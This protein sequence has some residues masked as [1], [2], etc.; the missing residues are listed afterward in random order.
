[1]SY[2]LNF[3][4]GRLQASFAVET[5][6]GSRGPLEAKQEGSLARTLVPNK[7]SGKSQGNIDLVK[8]YRWTLSNL[9]DEDL[10]EVPYIK[11]KEFRSTQA[12][13]T[14]QI[15]FY[16]SLFGDSTKSII[17][18]PQSTGNVLAPYEGIWPHENETGFTYKF[19]YFNKIGMELASEPWAGLDSIGEAINKGTDAV[20]SLFGAD[21]GKALKNFTAVVENGGKAAL[22]SQYPAVGVTDR[23]KIFMAHNDRNINISFVLYNTIS[24]QEW[25]DNSDFIRI[26]MSQNLFNKKDYITGVPPVFYS[27]YIPGQYFCWAA[28]VTNFKVE[29][30]GNQRLI[31][32]N[33]E[34]IVPDAYQ[35]DITLTELV[36]PSKNQ[37]E[38]LANGDAINHVTVTTIDSNIRLGT[39]NNFNNIA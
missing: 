38:A 6:T 36:K 5:V 39:Q 25:L 32:Y 4:R 31:D 29:H 2:P 9:P 30:L 20:G 10:K 24:T 7:L 12:S 23:P 8:D 33:G 28:S 22:M 35:V 3:L 21:M 16:S 34:I 27:V 18:A 13:I 37:F 1:M 26:F 15:K 14:K 11:L 17:S 19:P